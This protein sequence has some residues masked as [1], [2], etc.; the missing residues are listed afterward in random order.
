MS[1]LA[2]IAAHV[3][4]VVYQFR[5]WPDGRSA[6]P[7]ASQGIRD[8][9]GVEPE[10][11]KDDASAVFAVIHPDDLV[12]VSKSIEH[13]AEKMSV[14]RERFRVCH[15][16]G[17]VMWVEGESSPER[18]DDGS[19]IWHGYIRD[20]SERKAFEDQVQ[21]SG[22]RYESVVRGT[23]DGFLVVDM[24][25]VIKDVNRIFC[26]LLG[27]ELDE[28]IGMSVTNLHYGETQKDVADRVA[29]IRSH[30]GAQFEAEYL[31]KDGSLI[32][33]EVS[34]SYS[35]RTPD[36]FF[37]FARDIRVR[38]LEQELA[39]LRAKLAE[40]V[41]EGD[42]QSLLQVAVDT[43]ERATHSESGF[44]H[45]FM[46][47]ENT[48]G[49][50]TW[51]S[52]TV[53]GACGLKSVPSHYPLNKAG[54][55]ADAVREKRPVV[56][57]MDDPKAHALSLPFGHAP[58]ER[59]LFLPVIRS[60]QV[61]AIM[62]VGNKFRA[63]DQQDASLVQQVADIAYDYVERSRVEQQIQKMAFY[64]VL[65]GLPNRRL[66]TDRL[67]QLI[68]QA[69]REKTTIAVCYLDI[70]NFKPVNDRWGHEVGDQLLAAYTHRLKRELR[71]SDTLA[72][73][74]GDEF[75]LV[76][77]AVDSARA[78][79]RLMKRLLEVSARPIRIHHRR[80]ELSVS[81]GI[82]MFPN[83]DMDADGLIRDADHAM[84]MAKR[85]GRST[86]EFFDSEENRQIRE[87]RTLVK[88]L[89]EAIERE[90][91]V[92]YFQPRIELQSGEVAGFEVLIRWQHPERGLLFPDQFLPAIKDTHLEWCVDQ[93]VLKAAIARHQVWRQAGFIFSLS[94]NLTS[95]T[96]QLPD[97]PNRLKD[98]FGDDIENIAPYFELEVLEQSSIEDTGRVGKV[99]LECVEFGVH[100][101]LD[102]FGTGFSSLSYFHELPIDVV[103]IDQS[104]VRNMLVSQKDYGIV[105]GVLR[106]AK[107]INR[108]VVAEGVESL[109][110][111]L[112]LVLRGCHYAQGYGIARPMP[113]AQVVSWLEQ[114]SETGGQWRTL[115]KQSDAATAYSDLA[116]MLFSYQRWVAELVR[117]LNGADFVSYV[118]EHLH[119]A[120]FEEW[121]GGLGLIHYGR[122]A[123]WAS[124][125]ELHRLNLKALRQIC[126][127]TD[128]AQLK[129]L[130][131][132][133]E[134]RGGDIKKL[135]IQL[136]DEAE[137]QGI[138]IW[139]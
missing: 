131:A 2:K 10:A 42:Q 26:A 134:K 36:D 17:K 119:P 22:A 116:A 114:W 5:L 16:S 108:P 13:S 87:Q 71:D 54:I 138:S 132:D 88:E 110:L 124:L 139:N 86:Y 30:G 115:Q 61:V 45:F 79:D 40:E 130:R 4:G 117:S 29:H 121:L 91:L 92:L 84:Y 76:L 123:H 100:F 11:V 63:Y 99:M 47:D 133:F 21:Q 120:A 18:L 52:A 35:N 27:Y 83:D 125:Q 53:A 34:I 106:L 73:I 38:R 102:D 68:A 80:I 112:L 62:G 19:I 37:V 24:H 48:I 137:E 6:F 128:A 60:E 65:T 82:T 41:L 49:L 105:E 111:G 7:Y 69:R 122:L 8:I 97:F 95:S 85:R 9:Y 89:E 109:E 72:R 101:S 70:D 66:L 74:G 20:A 103:K 32:P 12:R 3:P 64:D 51:S 1:Q 31:A 44:F 56:M 135:I 77:P 23:K 25:G 46:A 58:V 57:D 107:A 126:M 118:S 39:Q 14:W 96:L 113:E 129:I 93:Y 127:Q 28:L 81:I 78:V 90:E 59:G 43:A 136:G 55:W 104:F 98:L 50:S 94:V 75:V 33:V 15:P 67:E